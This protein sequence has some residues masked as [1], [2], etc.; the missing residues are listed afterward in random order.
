MLAWAL[1]A[2]AAR[3]TIDFLRRAA[4]L[5]VALGARDLRVALPLCEASTSWW[6]R[7]VAASSLVTSSPPAP[8]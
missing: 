5:G 1:A 3:S 7:S 6:W 2:A 8:S 4:A